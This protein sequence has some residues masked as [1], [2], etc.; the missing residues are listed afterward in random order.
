[1]KTADTTSETLWAWHPRLP[2]ENA[3]VL[4][5]PPRP[6][7]AMKYLL[8][9]GYL[10][11]P[12]PLYLVVTIICWFYLIPEPAHWGEFAIDWI[13]QVYAINLGL[14]ALTAGGLHLFF[15]TFKRQGDERKFDLRKME[16]GNDK[17]LAGNQVWDNI[18]WTCVSGVTTMT[19]FE[20]GIMWAYANDLAPWLW[21]DAHPVWFAL[22]F[23]ALPFWSSLHFYFVHRLLHWKPLYKVAHALHHRNINIGPWSG[24]SMHPLEHLLYLSSPLIHLVVA[25]HPIHLFFHMNA[26]VLTAITS[27]TGYSDLLV[28][29][30]SLLGLGDFFHQLHHRY[31][32]CNYGGSD[33]PCDDWFGSFHDGTLEATARV[34]QLQKDRQTRRSGGAT[35]SV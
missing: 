5:W 10:L 2:I 13:L 25:S 20:V 33:V 23:V 16:R 24:L 21:W 8:G 32:D 14:V 28:R 6:I 34:R 9:R 19:A 27:H 7:P 17:F 12:I 3:Q 30:K 11:S 22:L 15:H 31:F 29:E 1:M 4:A 18:F 35:G 26:K